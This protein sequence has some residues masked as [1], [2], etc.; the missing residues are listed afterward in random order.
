MADYAEEPHLKTH[1]DVRPAGHETVDFLSAA[2]FWLKLGLISFGG[3][4]GQIAILHKS[5]WSGASGS[6]NGDSCTR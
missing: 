2:K 6:P 3:P 1:Q 4:A 5:W